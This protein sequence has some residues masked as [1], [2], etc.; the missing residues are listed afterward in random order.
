MPLYCSPLLQSLLGLIFSLSVFVCAAEEAT[1]FPAGSANRQ[2]YS[3]GGFVP[4]T[5]LN[6][7][8]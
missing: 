8:M 1:S 7:T 5:C 6:R 2:G 3:K 4:V